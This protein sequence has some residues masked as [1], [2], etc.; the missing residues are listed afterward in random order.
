[1]HVPHVRRSKLQIVSSWLRV[2]QTASTPMTLPTKLLRH[3][4]SEPV[5]RLTSA[6]HPSASPA[7]VK[8]P[9][10]GQMFLGG[11]SEKG[12]KGGLSCPGDGLRPLI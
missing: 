3:T 2:Q 10:S 8:R 4:M 11:K 7:M 9:R 6:G 5:Q 1:M 12:D